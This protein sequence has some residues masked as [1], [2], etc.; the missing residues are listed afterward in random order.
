MYLLVEYLVRQELRE[1]FLEEEVIFHLLA[2][3]AMFG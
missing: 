1:L 2:G 3:K